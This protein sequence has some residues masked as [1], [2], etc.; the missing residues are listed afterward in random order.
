MIKQEI[1]K[2]VSHRSTWL[3]IWLGVNLFYDNSYIVF[4]GD[5]FICVL[6]LHC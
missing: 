6:D 2:M 3:T 1:V 5:Y 4:Y